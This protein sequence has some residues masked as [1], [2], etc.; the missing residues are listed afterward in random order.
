MLWR[1]R[2]LVC[3]KVS[4]RVSHYRYDRNIG[5]PCATVYDLF[6]LSPVSMTF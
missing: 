1:T 4:T 6:V 5:I 3:N 2:S